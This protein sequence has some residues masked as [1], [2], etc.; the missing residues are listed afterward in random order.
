MNRSFDP[1][2]RRS[3]SGRKSRL[4]VAAVEFAVCIPLIVMIVLA[5]IEA[6]SMIFLKL[7]LQTTA[8]EAAR[9]AVAPAATAGDVVS[10]GNEVL[11]QR[12]IKDGSVQV[13]PANLQNVAAGANVTVT[14][15]APVA[16]NRIIAGWFFNGGSLSASTVM[17]RE[18]T[19]VQ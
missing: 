16:S 7:D 3:Y 12:N 15:T 4:G 11:D 6:S 8:Y 1:L 5:S 2:S 9:V 10:R 13:N 18:G 14:A 17:V 19:S